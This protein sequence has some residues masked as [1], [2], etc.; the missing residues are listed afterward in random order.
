MR[1]SGGCVGNEAGRR[2][3]WVGHAENTGGRVKD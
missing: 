2:G 3:G 1:H